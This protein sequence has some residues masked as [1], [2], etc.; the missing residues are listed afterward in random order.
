MDSDSTPVREGAFLPRRLAPFFVLTALF[1]A[2]CL[3]TRFDDVARVLPVGVG[4]GLLLATFP[5]LFIEGYFESRLDYGDASTSLPLWMRIKSRPVKLSFTFA[6]TYLAVVVLQTWD[7]SIG[8]IDPTPPPEWPLA[9]RAQFFA[10]MSA[11]M[12]FPNYL[13]ATS[14]LVPALR[15]LGTVAQRLPAFVAIFVL[16]LLGMGAGY[17]VVQA[18]ASASIGSGIESANSMLSAITERPAVAIGLAFAGVF[19]P[20]IFGALLKSDE[21]D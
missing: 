10:M 12:F 14:F 9:Q 1:H 8:P 17:G 19:V 3:V 15:T 18:F 16:G 6:F 11:G 7:I 20:M 13:A 5:L 4:A 2:I 21:D